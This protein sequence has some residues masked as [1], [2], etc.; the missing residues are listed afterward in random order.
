MQAFAKDLSRFSVSK[1]TVQFP[2]GKPL[3]KSLIR[4][5]VKF[6]VKEHEAGTIVW[7]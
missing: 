3:P 6:R 4:K 5:M 1:A 7:N 2:H